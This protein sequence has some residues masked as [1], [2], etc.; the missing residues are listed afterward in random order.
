VVVIT[1]VLVEVEIMVVPGDDRASVV[2]TAT[3]VVAVTMTVDVTLQDGQLI[4]NSLM[5][6]RLDLRCKKPTVSTAH[7]ISTD[8]RCIATPS[9]LSVGTA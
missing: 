7:T 6:K 8:P 5:V 4:S 3:F 1:V 9:K 2:V